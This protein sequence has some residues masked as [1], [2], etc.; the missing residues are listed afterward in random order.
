MKPLTPPALGFD[1]SA[2]IA[3]QTA[4]HRLVN[5]AL[6]DVS[7]DAIDPPVICD[8]TDCGQTCSDG[9]AY[10]DEHPAC[11]VCGAICCESKSCNW[12]D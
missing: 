5:V 9:S 10:C 8:V 11:R 1:L 3:L 6:Y 12:S 4:A 2:E 7:D